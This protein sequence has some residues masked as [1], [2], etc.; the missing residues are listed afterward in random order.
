MVL[1]DLAGVLAVHHEVFAE[2]LNTRLGSVYSRAYFRF[3]MR[4]TA[5]ASALVASDPTGDILGYVTGVTPE[6]SVDLQ[7]ALLLPAAFGLL[8]NPALLFAE[9]VRQKVRHRIFQLLQREKGLDVKPPPLPIPFF[10]LFGIGAAQK[11]AGRGVGK[12]LLDAFEEDCKARGMRAMLLS[13]FAN[14]KKAQYLYEKCGWRRSPG[15]EFGDGAH[16]Y[17]KLLPTLEGGL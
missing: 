14:N 12:A 15:N 5:V 1:S 11:A 4:E 10:V 3:F 16:Y 8:K 2:Y 7:R 6:N 17:T 9:D 13:V